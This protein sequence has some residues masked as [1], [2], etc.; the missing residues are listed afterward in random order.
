VITLLMLYLVTGLLLGG[1]SLPLIFRKFPPNYWY[2]FRVRATLE[3]EDIWYP[4]NEYAAKRLLW[5][6]IATVVAASVLFPLLTNVGIYA[7]AMGGIVLLGLAVSLIQSFLYLRSLID[8][9]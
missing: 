2:G 9:H 3:N 5:V 1:L 4:V 7:S 6:G 8:M